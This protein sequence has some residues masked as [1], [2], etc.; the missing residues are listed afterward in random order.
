M[1]RTRS[2]RTGRPT[3]SPRFFTTEIRVLALIRDGRS[4]KEIAE[5]LGTSFS[6]VSG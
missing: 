5:V 2:V 1:T 6:T 3:K 4:S